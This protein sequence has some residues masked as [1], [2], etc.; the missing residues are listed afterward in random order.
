MIRKQTWALAI[1]CLVLLGGV[2]NLSAASK[3]IRTDLTERNDITPEEVITGL[4]PSESQVRTRGIGVKSRG[5]QPGLATIAVT[6][7]FDF[8]SA[9]IRPEAIPN[10]R[11]LGSALQSPQLGPYR[12]RIEGHTD[13]TGP[14]AY[15]LQLSERRA[16]SVKQYLVEHFQIDADRLL[17]EGYGETEPM[18]SNSTREGRQKNRRAEF[19]NIGKLAASGS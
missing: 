15:N 1:L 11:S 12:I 7:H 17:I 18:I 6:I 9:A 2:Y 5:I 19:V 13:S 14:E 8:D 16:N 4:T 3:K 10:L